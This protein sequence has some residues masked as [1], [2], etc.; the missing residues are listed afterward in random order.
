MDWVVKL[1][2]KW[3]SARSQD[4]DV[5]V[6]LIDVY[7]TLGFHFSTPTASIEVGILDAGDFL[8]A[9]HNSHAPGRQDTTPIPTL[10][11]ATFVY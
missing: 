11:G 9:T 6:R 3:L 1:F 8:G 7:E 10:I 5:S 2:R 4:S